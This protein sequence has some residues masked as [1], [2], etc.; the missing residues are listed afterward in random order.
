MNTSGRTI[1]TRLNIYLGFAKAGVPVKS[2]ILRRVLRKG[3]RI[4]ERLFP[5]FL[6]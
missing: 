2:T 5:L 4:S 1:E 6:R 3:V